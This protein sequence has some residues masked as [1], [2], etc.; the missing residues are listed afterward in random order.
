MSGPITAQIDDMGLRAK[1]LKV[2]I[3]LNG[4]SIALII[5]VNFVCTNAETSLRLNAGGQNE[6][7]Q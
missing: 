1:D 6:F 3:N 2:K 7:D 4:T 5:K